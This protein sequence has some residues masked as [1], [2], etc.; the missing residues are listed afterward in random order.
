M[1]DLTKATFSIFKQLYEFVDDYFDNNKER[2]IKYKNDDIYEGEFQ[3]GFRSGFGKM[4]YSNGNIYIGKWAIDKEHG[5]GIMTYKNG[6]IYNGSWIFGIRC[7]YGKYALKI[8]DLEEAK[9]TIWI[10]DRPLI[11]NINQYYEN[12]DHEFDFESSVI[13]GNS[14]CVICNDKMFSKTNIGVCNKCLTNESSREIELKNMSSNNSVELN[15]SNN[16]VKLNSSNNSVK[17][18]SSNNSVEL[19]NSNNSVN[20]EDSNNMNDSIKL[21]NWNHKIFVDDFTGNKKISNDNIIEELLD[22]YPD[23]YN[24]NGNYNILPKEDK[25]EEFDLLNL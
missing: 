14:I 24:W 11:E 21:G 6:S 16:S 10:S 8:E 15:S 25:L 13:I 23:I 3:N 19:N 18:N 7:G 5:S 9:E 1:N 17:L 22:N 2:I 4:T 20:L 12:V